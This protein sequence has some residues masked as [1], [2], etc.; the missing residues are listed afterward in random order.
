MDANNATNWPHKQKSVRTDLTRSFAIYAN[1]VM[2]A[3]MPNYIKCLLRCSILTQ[4]LFLP[5]GELYENFLAFTA[6]Y[7]YSQQQCTVESK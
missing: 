7:S 5:Q 1:A 6:P 3:V 2:H 4:G